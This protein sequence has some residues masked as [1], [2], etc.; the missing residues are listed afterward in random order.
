[1]RKVSALEGHTGSVVSYVWSPVEGHTRSA[2]SC[3]WSPDGNT[4]ATGSWSETAWLWDAHTFQ[5]LR[6]FDMP[7]HGH[8]RSAAF[9]S[10]GR[11]L[12]STSPRDHWIWG[13]RSNTL[14]KSVRPAH[15]TDVRGTDIP[16]AFYAPTMRLAVTFSP[17]AVDIWDVGS[18]SGG[19]LFEI[20]RAHV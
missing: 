6:V 8:V 18:E 19:R 2:V 3:A 9:S 1:M 17:L 7:G 10:D 4:I 15:D 16:A 20:G 14:H 5:Q 12:C 11:W 13:V